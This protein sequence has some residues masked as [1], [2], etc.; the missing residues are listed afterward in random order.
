MIARTPWFEDCR[1]E[2][3]EVQRFVKVTANGETIKRGHTYRTNEDLTE[4][5]RI[6]RPHAKRWIVFEE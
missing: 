3:S 4:W 2:V 6:I 5:A 1:R